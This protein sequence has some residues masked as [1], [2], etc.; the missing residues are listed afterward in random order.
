MRG[1][2]A[3]GGR[4]RALA[5]LAAVVLVIIAFR[6]APARF[7]VV[8]DPP[9][10]VDAAVVLAGDPDYERTTYAARLVLVG[11]ARWLVVTGGDPGP[12]DSAR[13]LR[14]RARA[15]GVPASAILSEESSRGTWESLLNLRSVLEGA[16]IRSVALVT[17]PYHS[18]RA[19]RVARK[20]WPG[21]HVVSRPAQPSFWSPDGWWRRGSSR[22]IVIDEWAKLTAYAVML[23]L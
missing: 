4:L 22:R 15:L 1:A 12:G 21:V 13:S 3:A 14:A 9:V 20:V 23:R 18:R 7:L 11:Q 6:N 17:S 19:L 2:A 10:P 16:G 5:A 8:A